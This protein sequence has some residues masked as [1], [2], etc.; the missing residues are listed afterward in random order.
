VSP[1]RAEIDGYLEYLLKTHHQS[2]GLIA[3][4]EAHCI[5]QW[6]HHFRPPYKAIPFGRILDLTFWWSLCA[7]RK[8]SLISTQRRLFHVR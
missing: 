2:I 8:P 6:G 4:D 3:I 7:Y 1:E 5:S